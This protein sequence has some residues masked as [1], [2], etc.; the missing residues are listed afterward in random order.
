MVFTFIGDLWRHLYSKY[1]KADYDTI[2]FWIA[3][4]LQSIIRIVSPRRY[5]WNQCWD[6]I[7]TLQFLSWNN[8]VEFDIRAR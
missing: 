4:D 7:L 2:Q 5:K 8:G 3:I 6:S 1:K